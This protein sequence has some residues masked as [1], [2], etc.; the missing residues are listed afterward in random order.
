MPRAVEAWS[1]NHWMAENSLKES[2]LD[3]DIENMRD[4]CAR[5]QAGL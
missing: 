3:R 2:N 1:P 5:T 4:T